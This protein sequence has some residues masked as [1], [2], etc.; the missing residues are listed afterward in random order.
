[1]T[2]FRGDYAAIALRE[3]GE[4]GITVPLAETFPGDT[5]AVHTFD[6]LQVLHRDALAEVIS[7][8]HLL[9]TQFEAVPDRGASLGVH[10]VQVAL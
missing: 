1:M 10:L 8:D 4:T 5:S 2:V 3:V 9:T 7:Q 6:L